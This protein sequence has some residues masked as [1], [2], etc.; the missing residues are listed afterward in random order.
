[1]VFR[2]S[3]GRIKHLRVNDIG[4]VWGGDPTDSLYTEVIVQLDT[5]NDDYAFGFELRVGDDNLPA[6][7]AMLATL[8][9]AFFNNFEVGLAYDIEEGKKKGHL[10]R[11]DLM[12]R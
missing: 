4:H 5:L 2:G 9:E 1:M 6:R 3:Q 8:R 10:R 12:R 11:I 7:L